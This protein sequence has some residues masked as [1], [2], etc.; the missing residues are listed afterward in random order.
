MLVIAPSRTARPLERSLRVAVPRP[1]SGWTPS[2]TSTTAPA[3][4]TAA[5]TAADA[6]TTAASPAAASTPHARTPS[7]L[8]AVHANASRRPPRAALRTTIAVAGPGTIDTRTATGRKARSV[9]STGYGAGGGTTRISVRRGP[10]AG[11]AGAAL[12]GRGPGARP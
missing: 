1:R 9:R 6:A 3:S 2:T 7:E 8:P 4:F 12:G 5:N 11:G 10:P